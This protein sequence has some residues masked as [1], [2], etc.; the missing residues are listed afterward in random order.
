V[1]LGAADFTLAEPATVELLA[2]GNGTLR[3]WADDKLVHQRTAVRP[4]RADSDRVQADLGRGSH[5]VAVEVASAL[6]P[7]E[8]HLRFRRRSS[9]LERERLI[10]MALSRPGDPGHGRK[11]LEEVERS[12]CLKCHRVGDRG[13]RIGPE[14][15]GLGGRFAR[16]TIVESILEPSRS[17]APG[18]ESVTVA[19]ADGRVLSGVRSAETDRTLTLGDGEGCRHEIAKADIESRTRHP[20]SAMPDGLEKRLTPEEFV[21]LIAYLAA[22]K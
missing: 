10:Q 3:I 16:I 13:E 4:F 14:L 15:T 6:R 7:V 17:V 5:R 20:Q 18:Y 11:V 2:S 1:C 21:D 8:F 19:L 22:Q 12:L 9:S